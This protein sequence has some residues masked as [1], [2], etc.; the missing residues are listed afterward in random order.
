VIV[1]AKAI[2]YVWAVM[3]E[4]LNTLV[5]DLAVKRCF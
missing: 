1:C 4:Q 2:I 5:A 3:I